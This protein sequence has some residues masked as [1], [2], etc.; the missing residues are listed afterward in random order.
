[1]TNTRRRK[2]KKGAKDRK[3]TTIFLNC[4]IQYARPRKEKDV[5]EKQEESGK[6]RKKRKYLMA[7][8]KECFL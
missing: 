3:K 8:A 4:N 5:G 6:R 1:L 7:T 2:K